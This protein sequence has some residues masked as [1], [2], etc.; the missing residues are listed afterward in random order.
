MSKK[1]LCILLSKLS[2]FA[3]P[4][5][6]L[7]QYPTDS[8][9]AGDCLWF[10]DLQGDIEGKTIA[11]LGSGTGILGLGALVLGAKKAFLVDID[12][13]SME[14]AMKNLAFV[15]EQTEKHF[16]AVFSAGDVIVF[17]EK[18]DVVIMNPPFGTKNENI[19]TQFLLKAMTIAPVIYSFHKAS[20]KDY[21]D[22]LV[23]DYGFKTTHYKEYDFPLKQTM[24][25]H[26]KKI[27]KIKVGLW[28]IS[29]N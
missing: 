7:E 28:R 1:E 26:K 5:M 3:D 6:R 23:A 27:E 13:K 21:I 29:K 25:H 9:I 19:D 20:T 11:D 16:N 10:A 17:D 22:K 18:A 15:E 2:V 24:E 12:T 4:S 14:L 8:E